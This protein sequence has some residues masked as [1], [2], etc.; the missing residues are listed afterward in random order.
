[1]DDIITKEQLIEQDRQDRR[2]FVNR[3]NREAV[4]DR[5]SIIAQ[6]S[7]AFEVAR[8]NLANAKKALA[9]YQ[10]LEYKEVEL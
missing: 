5:I 6:C 1:M 3:K 10:M 8:D 9:D 4:R 2:E 7:A